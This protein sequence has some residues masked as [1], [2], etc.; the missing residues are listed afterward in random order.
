MG[1]VRHVRTSGF[2]ASPYG[3]TQEAVNQQDNVA[4]RLRS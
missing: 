2:K 4:W 1:D 3:V